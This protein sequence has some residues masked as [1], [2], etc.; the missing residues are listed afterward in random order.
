MCFHTVPMETNDE[1]PVSQW[2]TDG[3]AFAL[4][5]MSMSRARPPIERE[6][7]DEASKRL[8]RMS[9]EETP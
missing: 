6:V 2:S 5:A 3:L 8:S 7:L 4:R 9:D 1:I